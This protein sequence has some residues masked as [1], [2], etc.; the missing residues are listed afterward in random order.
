[1]TNTLI[2]RAALAAL[3]LA[4]TSPLHAEQTGTGR[5]FLA[6]DDSTRR[7]AI[8]APDGSY[9]WELKIGGIHDAHVLPNGNVLLQQGFQKIVEVAPDKKVVW[10]YDSGKMN[11]NEGKRVEVH[12]FQRVENGLTMI[13]ESGPGRIIEVDKDGK[14]QKEIQL[15]RNKPNAHSDTRLVRKIANGNY[16]VAHEADGFVREYDGSGKVVWEYEVPLFGKEKKGGHG[17]EAWGNSVFCAV[18][19]ANGNTLIGSGN[20][21]SVLEVTPAKEIV[22]KVEQND[23]PGITLAW[24][25]CVERLANG[26]TMIGNCHAG[27]NHP[28]FIEV[29][30]DKKVVWSFKDFKNF[31]NSMP[32][33]HVLGA[34]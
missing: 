7:L 21:H 8:I 19:L 27:P 5:R 26:N 31:G 25:T 24:V 34:K 13:A 6:G 29:T 33:Q 14:I 22:W 16:L 1:M 32:V 30:K 20:G 17:P 10:E 15:K 12:A 2:C 28:Q 18:R 23:L 9:E 3:C 4:L 11:G